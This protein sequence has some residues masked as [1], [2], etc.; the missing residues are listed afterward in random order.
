MK[1]NSSFKFESV[2]KGQVVRAGC[3]NGRLP[4][5]T[6]AGSGFAS[7]IAWMASG[8]DGECSTKGHCVLLTALT[9]LP[10]CLHNDAK[11]FSELDKI[12]QDK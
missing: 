6:C 9:T 3:E 2:M 5:P 1:S 7:L 11:R 10:S 8:Q 4:H 12:S